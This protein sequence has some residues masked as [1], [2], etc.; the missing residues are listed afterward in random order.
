MKFGKNLSK[1][2]RLTLL[3]YFSQIVSMAVLFVESKILTTQLNV[4]DYGAYN[5]VL[6]TVSMMVTVLS[7]NLGHGFLR[8]ASS[9]DENKKKQAFGTVLIFQF[10]LLCTAYILVSP[11]SVEFSLFLT[12]QKAVYPYIF[13]ALLGLMSSLITNVQNYMLASGKDVVMVKQN[14]YRIIANVFFIS[15]AVFI[16]SSIF[17]ALTGYF[18]SEVVCFAYFS[19]S[20]H[21]SYRHLAFNRDIFSLI[22]RFSIPLILSSISYWVINSC[23]RYFINYYWGLEDAGRFAIANR[24][25]VMLVTIFT[26]LSTIFLSNTSRLYDSGEIKRVSYWFSSMIRVFV[27]VAGAGA[28]FLIMSHRTI[29]LILSNEEYLFDGISQ[30]YLWLCMGSIAFGLFQIVSKCYDL[31]KKVNIISLIWFAILV[32]NVL[33]NFLLIPKYSLLGASWASSITFLVGFT[34]AVIFR[35][36]TVNMGVSWLKLVTYIVLVLFTSYIL[37]DF[38]AQYNLNMWVELLIAFGVFFFAIAIG[39][40]LKILK[41]NE[42]KELMLNK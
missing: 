4:N 1:A 20:N 10:S 18:L 6:T 13:I 25:P 35:P 39:L 41:V 21:I 36:R 19:I 32:V 3:S 28:A 2:S 8:F 5:Q 7:L 22:S 14:I 17:S 34:L 33:L 9:F 11:L 40:A 24:L 15:S 26:L 27:L 30:F 38:I 16:K 29:T 42:L 31:E 23:N 37:V 12:N